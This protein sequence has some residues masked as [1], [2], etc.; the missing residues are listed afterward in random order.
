[1]DRRR[2]RV[3]HS[4]VSWV[5][6]DRPHVAIEQL[7]PALSTICG[8]IDAIML[9][10]SE[11]AL[12]LLEASGQR[13]A[14]LGRDAGSDLLPTGRALPPDGQSALGPRVKTNVLGH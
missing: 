1:M 4:L 5:D 8:A 9:D 3:D 13:P 14:R 7:L 12:R 10:A 11:H 6:G 2:A